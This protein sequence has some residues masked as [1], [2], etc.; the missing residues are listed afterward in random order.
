MKDMNN[1]N[2]LNYK[3]SPEVIGDGN[4]FSF[5][6]LN[7]NFNNSENSDTSSIIDR[8]KKEE[9]MS[10]RELIEQKK[11]YEDKDCGSNKK[12]K[13]INKK[14]YE[15]NYN[16][17]NN[18]INENDESNESIDSDMNER[19]NHIPNNNNNNINLESN[20]NIKSKLFELF[21]RDETSNTIDKPLDKKIKH[22]TQQVKLRGTHANFNFK[23]KNNIDELSYEQVP[24]ITQISENRTSPTFKTNINNSNNN[25]TNTK[26]K[27][28]NNS[29]LVNK[30]KKKDYGNFGNL[31]IVQKYNK[32]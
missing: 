16:N 23:T 7:N 11:K 13:E 20:T 25:N 8:N 21:K 29:S 28:Y 19:I 1:S 31:G 30:E 5:R 22:N 10:I 14:N 32:L 17:I 12:H 26:S 6:N 15:I 9:R 18:K 4:F 2:S 24:F 27:T 3:N